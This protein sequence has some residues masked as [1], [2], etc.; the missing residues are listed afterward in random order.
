M[1]SRPAVEADRTER[2]A[3]RTAAEECSAAEGRADRTAAELL[4]RIA[5]RLAVLLLRIALRLVV[6]L[7]RIALRLTVL[8]LSVAH[9]SA[10]AHRLLKA[11]AGERGDELVSLLLKAPV[12]SAVAAVGAVVGQLELDLA[13]IGR[14]DVDL[15]REFVCILIT[16]RGVGNAL[17]LGIGT[18]NLRA[19]LL[20]LKAGV[21][22]LRKR[23]DIGVLLA[24][25]IAAAH[26]KAAL[27]IVDIDLGFSAEGTHGI[28]A[29]QVLAV[30]LA[31]GNLLLDILDGGF[32]SAG[33]E[34]RKLLN[35]ARAHIAVLDLAVAEQADLLAADIA[36]FL[37][38]K[39]HNKHS[40][41]FRNNRERGICIYPFV[42]YD[43]KLRFSQ[44]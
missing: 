42:Y 27:R 12:F 22:N 35:T 18:V 37:V 19:V 15:D 43:I 5:L 34:G 28:E 1:S 41:S 23:D 39:S 7:L 3:G 17:A 10:V 16:G 21:L 25:I 30:L 8:L 29:V 2:A 6:L 40:V 9:R 14:V 26:D 36:I 13:E 11:S 32:F 33:K 44:E 4:L 31:V 38:K 20:N 24:E